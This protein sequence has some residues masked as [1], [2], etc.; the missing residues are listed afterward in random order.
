LTTLDTTG[1]RDY[2]AS[3]MR[4]EA[5]RTDTA[6]PREHPERALARA[7]DLRSYADEVQRLP[8]DDE[9]LVRLARCWFPE[10]PDGAPHKSA[11]SNQVIRAYVIE[12]NVGGLDD[13]INRIVE[14]DEQ[15]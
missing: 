5:H 11:N 1:I 9:R 8:E 10:G 13:L 12:D 7:D 15:A 4:Q 14:L 3:V 2:L 6:P